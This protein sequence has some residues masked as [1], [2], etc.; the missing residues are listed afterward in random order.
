MRKLYE[1]K[2][3]Y[4]CN[5]G[6]YYCPG[7]KQP[8]LHYASWGDFLAEWGNEE[9]DFDYN[10]LFRWDW[11]EEDPE[12]GEA[13]YNGDDYYRNGRLSLFW[14]LQR[15][16]LY[17]WTTVEVCRAD[18]PAVREYLLPRWEHLQALWEGISE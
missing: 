11:S 1:V 4:Y 8:G 10:L 13:N 18:E 12:T 14:M 17:L 5:E 3:P 16:G 15:K 2:H 9:T 6:N 7:N